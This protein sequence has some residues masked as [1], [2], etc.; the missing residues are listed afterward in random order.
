[1]QLEIFKKPFGMQVGPEHRKGVVW[2]GVTHQ[3]ID[4]RLVT[5]HVGKIV[6]IL[7][8]LQPLPLMITVVVAPQ[9]IDR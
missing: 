2:D 4:V 9:L 1:M 6:G 5:S 3:M 7:A 8:H